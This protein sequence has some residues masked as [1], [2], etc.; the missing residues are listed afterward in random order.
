MALSNSSG[1]FSRT[2]NLME[3]MAFTAFPIDGK[4]PWTIWETILKDFSS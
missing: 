3:L 2:A 4:E 1:R